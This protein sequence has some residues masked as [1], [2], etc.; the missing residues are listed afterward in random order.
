MKCPSCGD[1]GRQR[2]CGDTFTPR[3]VAIYACFACGHAYELARTENGDSGQPP[4]KLNGDEQ[5]A[6]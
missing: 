2:Y 6:S 1:V 4:D 3:T 5:P